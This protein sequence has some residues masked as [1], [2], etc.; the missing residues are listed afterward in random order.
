M[1][2]PPDELLSRGINI[3]AQAHTPKGEWT[4]CSVGGMIEYFLSP[5]GE[6]C[7]VEECNKIKQTVVRPRGPVQIQVN[8]RPHSTQ[9]LGPVA[10]RKWPE[11]EPIHPKPTWE[12]AANK[13]ENIGWKVPKLSTMNPMQDLYLN[14]L[15]IREESIELGDMFCQWSATLTMQEMSQNFTEQADIKKYLRQR[16]PHAFKYMPRPNRKPSENIRSK[17]LGF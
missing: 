11:A 9:V 16:E 12:E 17:N 7:P 6:Q 15:R 3:P 10:A 1:R 13:L 14:Q 8:K 5:T 2:R 4:T